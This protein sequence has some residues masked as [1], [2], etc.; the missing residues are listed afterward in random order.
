MLIVG[1]FEFVPGKLKIFRVHPPPKTHTL[2]YSSS[3]SK[4]F[5]LLSFS[6][7]MAI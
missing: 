5:A 1:H 7:S 2:F 4:I 3:S 6:A